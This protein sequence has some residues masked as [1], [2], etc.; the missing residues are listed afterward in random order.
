M[1]SRVDEVSLVRALGVH[2][3]IHT[4][5]T[6]LTPRFSLDKTSLALT[7]HMSFNSLTITGQPK[8]SLLL[9]IELQLALI[10][11]PAQACINHAHQLILVTWMTLVV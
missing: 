9:E 4:S 11:K 6:K 7:K 5:K 8:T 10:I 2:Q 3:N 1:D